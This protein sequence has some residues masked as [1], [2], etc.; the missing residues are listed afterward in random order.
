MQNLIPRRQVT[1]EASLLLARTTARRGIQSVLISTSNSAY[2]LRTSAMY[3]A[4][5]N[6]DSSSVHKNIHSQSKNVETVYISTN[7]KMDF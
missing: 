5:A 3:R 7:Y 6:G 4:V 2:S 1:N